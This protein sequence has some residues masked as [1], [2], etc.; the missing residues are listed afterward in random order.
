M[1]RHC[2]IPT[3]FITLSACEHKNPDLLK[4]LYNIRENKNITHEAIH[5]DIADKTKLIREDPV[6]CVR[7]IEERFNLIMSVLQNEYGPFGE[8][9]VVDYFQ[10]REFQARGSV[11]T[12]NLLYCKNALNYDEE[13]EEANKN[14]IQ[15]IDKNITCAYDLK[16]SLIR[17]Q[18]HRHKATCYK[19]RKNKSICRFNIPM[20][21]MKETMIVKPLAENEQSKNDKTNRK[22]IRS[23]M[24]IFFEKN[25]LVSFKV[26]RIR[27][28]I[29][30]N[31]YVIKN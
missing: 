15:W 12:H 9:Y 16:N 7:Y 10:R 5:L 30:S 19:G 22:K 11:H 2:G 20:F 24:Q 28:G 31:K 17:L 4:I 27:K 1:I 26:E 18:I 29:Y 14:L 21:V 6:T 13:N 3:L 8:N 25:K 23:L